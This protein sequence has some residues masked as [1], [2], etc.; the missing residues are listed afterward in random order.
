MKERATAEMKEG[1]SANLVKGQKCSAPRKGPCT[2]PQLQ[3]SSGSGELCCRGAE[4]G[5]RAEV[6]ADEEKS[7]PLQHICM[8]QGS[9]GKNLGSPERT[10]GHLLG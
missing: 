6:T 3:R 8:S 10:D 2:S 9:P 7:P 4:A 1:S 5:G